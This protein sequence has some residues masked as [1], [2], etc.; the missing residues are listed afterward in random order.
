MLISA[1]RYVSVVHMNETGTLHPGL[2]LPSVIGAV[3]AL[4]GLWGWK[5]FLSQPLV[6]LLYRRLGEID[7]AMAGLMLRFRAGQLRRR[8]P[9]TVV[10]QAVV[11]DA[12]VATVRS[13]P[14]VVADRVWPLEFAWLVRRAAHEAAIYGGQLRI[15]L[16]QPEMAALLAACP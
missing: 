1:S 3:R 7:R 16:E 9:S 14:S 15:V 12:A 6:M 11:P 8:M 10:V 4:V 2:T 5:R 13:A